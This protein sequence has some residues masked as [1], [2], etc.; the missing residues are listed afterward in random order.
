MWRFSAAASLGDSNDLIG[1]LFELLLI[2]FVVGLWLRLPGRATAGG[3]AVLA[4]GGGAAGI[5]AL[6]GILMV[7]DMVPQAVASAISGVASVLIGA[8]VGLVSRQARGT[9]VLSPF[10]TRAGQ[11]IGL[12]IGVSALLVGAG[13]ALPRAGAAVAAIVVV[14]VP[15]ILGYIAMP[16]WVTWSA[17]T[18]G[19]S[20]GAG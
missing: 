5:A 12:S 16:V 19:R 13:L 6:A 20:R 4:L 1:I 2:P 17:A 11:A 8:W 10:L 9:G 14:A 7:T 3:R 18:L 15:G